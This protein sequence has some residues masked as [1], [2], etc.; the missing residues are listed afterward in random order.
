MGVPD[1]GTYWHRQLLVPATF[2]FT[3]PLSSFFL[4]LV[5]YALTLFLQVASATATVVDVICKQQFIAAKCISDFGEY[6]M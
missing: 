1:D 2:F 3:P 5:S 6:C 4:P